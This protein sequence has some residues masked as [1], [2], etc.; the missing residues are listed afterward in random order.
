M[1]VGSDD[2]RH[3]RGGQSDHIQRAQPP[4]EVRGTDKD[5]AIAV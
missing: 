2:R 3:S 5:L 4:Q 1:H